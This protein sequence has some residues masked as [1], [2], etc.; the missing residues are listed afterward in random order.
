MTTSKIISDDEKKDEE[1]RFLRC[2]AD[3]G[4]DDQG[5]CFLLFFLIAAIAETG[6]QDG[7]LDDLQWCCF[8]TACSHP[9]LILTCRRQEL[10]ELRLMQKE[11]HRAQSALNAKLESQRDQMLRRFDQEMNVS[12]ALQCSGSTYLPCKQ[13]CLPSVHPCCQ[14][15]KKHY[16]TEQENLEKHQKQTIEK[17]EESHSMKL[18]DET[19]RIKADQ[20]RD[21][22]KF[23]DHLK[24]RKKEVRATQ[25]TREGSCIIFLL[26]VQ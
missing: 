16:D 14:A 22:H 10:R 5:V 17:M 8:V 11:A 7:L 3:C 2:V 15:K 24:H 1:M 6:L 23:Q 13:R 25:E 4:N 19:K 26:K 21:H 18:K 12:A 9:V 20:E